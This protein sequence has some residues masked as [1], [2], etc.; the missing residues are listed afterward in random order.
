MSKY[1]ATVRCLCGRQ[2]A[3]VTE[4]K[5]VTCTCGIKLY[6]KIVGGEIVPMATA[7]D[8]MSVK[9]MRYKRPEIAALGRA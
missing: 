9:A 2:V 8:V 1:I 3:K 5:K 4:N 7:P 6:L